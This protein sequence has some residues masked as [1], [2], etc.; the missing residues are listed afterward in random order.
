MT[1]PSRE[2]TIEKF[3]GKL[4]KEDSGFTMMLNDTVQNIKS[5]DALAIYCYLATK[6][7]GWIINTVEISRHFL[8][9][10]RDKTKNA[11][12]YLVGLGLLIPTEHRHKGKIISKSYLLKIRISLVT[13]PEKPAPE[14]PSLVNNEKPAPEKPAPEK[15]RH[16]KQRSIKNKESTITPDGVQITTPDGVLHLFSLFKKYGIRSIPN[17]TK[18]ALDYVSAGVAVVGDLDRYL[19]YLRERCGKWLDAVYLDNKGRER[20]NDFRV[21]LNPKMIERIVAGDFE[22]VA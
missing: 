10:G 8:K 11:M 17:P 4:E 12:R 14:N 18:G 20:S 3:T 21:I 22:D 6:P 5:S 7:S 1:N 13:E 2:N 19:S 15:R 16:I 9:M